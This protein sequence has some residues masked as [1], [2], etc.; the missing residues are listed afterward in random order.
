MTGTPTIGL[1]AVTKTYSS[2]LPWERRN[3]DAVRSVDLLIAAGETLA[4]VGESGSG[5]STI[6]RLCLGLIEPSGGRVLLEGQPFSALRGR[7]RGRLSAVL[8]HPLSSLNPRL[9][10]G[11]SVAEPLVVA[12]SISRLPMDASSTCCSAFSCSA[13]GAPR[14]SRA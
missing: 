9:R 10:V 4:L 11:T 13:T 12:G 3:V 7:L 5:K 2:G 8:Q 6:G 14:S 1:E